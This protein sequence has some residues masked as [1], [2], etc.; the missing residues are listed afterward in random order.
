MDKNLLTYSCCIAYLL[1]YSL[2]VVHGDEIPRSCSQTP[3]PHVCNHYMGAAN[4][5][6]PTHDVSSSYSYF[7]FHD[8]ALRVTMDQAIEAHK[9][10]SIM[11]LDNFK[12]KYAK[13]AW[14]DCLKLY[15]DT[16]NKLNRSMSSNN[17]IDRL[18]WLS[19]SIANQQTCQIGFHDFNLSS[20][21]NHF[22]NMLTNFSKLISNSLA[23]NNAMASASS[24]SSLMNKK[25][26][27]SGRRL[28]LSEDGFPEWLSASDRKLLQ[29]TREGPKADIVVAQDGSGNYK[30]ISEGIAAASKHGGRRVVVYVKAGV[31]KE[32]VVVKKS[33]KNVMIVGDGIDATIVTGSKSAQVTTTFRSATFGV[34]GDGFIARDI[35]FENTAGPQKHQ[36]VA[37]RSGSDHSVFYRCS[38]K[39]YQDTLY[40]YSQRQF[41]RE[42]DIHGTVDFIFGDAVAVLQSCNIYVRKPMSNQQNTVTAQGRE[43]PNENTGIIIHNSRIIGSAGLGSTKTF[44][45]RPWKKYSRTV[46]MKSSLDGSVNPAGWKEWSGSFALSTL[47]YG[48]YMNSGPGADTS[49]RVRWPGFHVI[50]SPSEAGKFTVGNFLVGDSWIP[51]TGVPFDA[52]L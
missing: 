32:N 41:Y 33:V 9:L 40:V 5:L 27:G 36:A 20:H 34:S 24:S 31:Y 22:P 51:A 14:K 10:V 26:N 47:Y 1:V 37:L 15:E 25:Q 43:D 8:L 50:T 30:T 19:A 21:L 28:L 17:P 13:L 49:R 2:M 7:S 29:A 23:I 42:C 48:E 52:G 45:G 38:F 18:T 3:H 11:K 46:V 6:Q 35:T 16:V 44:L 12:N 39:G 4:R